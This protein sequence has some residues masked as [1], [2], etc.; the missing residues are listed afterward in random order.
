MVKIS[1]IIKALNEEANIARAIES[2]LAAIAPFEGEVILADSCSSDQTV[3][4]ARRYP[5]KVVQLA[6][7]AD[8]CCGA[9][10]QLGFQHSR[11]EYVHLLD[12]DME[13]KPEFLSKAI[14]TLEADATLAGVCGFIRE[15]RAA[16][17]EFQRRAQKLE[18][19]RLSGI[20]EST[21]LS[22]GG[23]YRRAALDSVGY[24]S[25][26]NLH[27]YEEFDLGVRLR[28]KGWRLLALP[29]HASDH[30]SYEKRTG[31]LLL[32]RLR[33]G[34]MLGQGEMLRAAWAGGYLHEAG[35]IVALRISAALLLFW[36]GVI[37]ALLLGMSAWLAAVGAATAM[38]ALLGVLAKRHKSWR[39]PLNSLMIWHLVAGGLLL[40]LLRRRVSPREPIPSRVLH[41]AMPAG[42]RL[43][44]AE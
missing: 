38:V 39:S 40:G 14:A 26:R 35:R 4:I 37:G 32:H 33:S 31:E 22:G 30:Y 28:A 20:R 19:L 29:D 42:S 13:L 21:E 18:K 10:A 11:G 34:S 36:A 15:M 5:I 1:V 16:N 9:G 2:A 6:R 27:G 43:L 25:D 24:M 44:A 17:H 23:L 3:E 41:D 7:S 8:R 12:G